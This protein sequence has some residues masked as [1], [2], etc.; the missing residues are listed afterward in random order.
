MSKALQR[1]METLE[2]EKLMIETRLKDQQD[3][4]DRISLLEENVVTLTAENQRFRLVGNIISQGSRTGSM[5]N[6][7]DSIDSTSG[8]DS[9]PLKLAEK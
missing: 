3:L 5:E 1:D 9:D 2:Q 7:N 4:L 8:S 6:L